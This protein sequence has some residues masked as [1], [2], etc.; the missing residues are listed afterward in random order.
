MSNWCLVRYA[1]FQ[2]ASFIRFEVILEKHE[3]AVSAPLAGRGLIVLDCHHDNERST[4]QCGVILC[5]ARS[6]G[7]RRS[8]PD[9]LCWHQSAAISTTQRPLVQRGYIALVQRDIYN[10]D[11][12]IR[13]HLSVIHW[14][15]ELCLLTALLISPN[16]TK[17]HAT[18]WDTLDR[19]DIIPNRMDGANHYWKPLAEGCPAQ[20]IGI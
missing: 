4:L 9:A 19:I 20:K 10:S 18:V 14:S 8:V 11:S 1:K 2:V 17:G 16:T 12:Q 5:R 3:G 13:P 6:G 15:S 7:V